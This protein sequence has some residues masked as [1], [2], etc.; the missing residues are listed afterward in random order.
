MKEFANCQDKNFAEGSCFGE[1][2]EIRKF[3]RD[4]GLGDISENSFVGQILN[5][6]LNLIKFNV[7]VAEGLGEGIGKLGEEAGKVLDDLINIEFP[8]LP[9]IDVPDPCDYISC[10]KIELPEIDLFATPPEALASLAA[11][12]VDNAET[13]RIK[14]AL[15]A[16]NLP[17]LKIRFSVPDVVTA[18]DGVLVYKIQD[19]AELFGIFK[20]SWDYLEH[21]VNSPAAPWALGGISQPE[22]EKTVNDLTEK[23]I[24]NYEIRERWAV[25]AS[26]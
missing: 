25:G 7:R 6:H 12:P 17:E 21:Q 13:S 26:D 20:A 1:N 8:P 23:S 2:N 24:R 9:E 5:E 16:L 10:P 4:I 18:F 11:V 19:D 14:A 22:I 15:K 3:I